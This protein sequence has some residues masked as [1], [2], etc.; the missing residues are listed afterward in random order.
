MFKKREKDI[1]DFWLKKLEEKVSKLQKRVEDMES[2]LN[3]KYVTY[4]E[5]TQYEKNK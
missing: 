4:P 2:H 5:K 1:E 3:I